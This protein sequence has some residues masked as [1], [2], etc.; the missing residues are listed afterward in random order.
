MPDVQMDYDLMEEMSK[1][2]QNGATQLGETTQAMEQLANTMEQGALLGEGGD[3]FADALRSRL[4]PRLKK[5][6]EKF[7]ELSKDV[8]GALRDLRDGDKDAASRFK[9]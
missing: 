8:T 5:L 7:G 3:M 1:I 4:G 9:G 2:F 6:Q